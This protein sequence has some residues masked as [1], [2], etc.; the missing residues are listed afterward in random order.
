MVRGKIVVIE[1]HGEIVSSIE[2]NG[3]MYFE[4]LGAELFQ[5][6]SQIKTFDEY[7]NLVKTFNENF[8]NYEES[9]FFHCSKNYCDLK[10]NYF[11][12]WG[13]DYIYWKNLSNQNY[14]ITDRNGKLYTMLPNQTWV[15][16]FGKRIATNFQ[17]FEAYSKRE[18]EMAE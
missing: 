17:E 1:P 13:S 12:K 18:Q 14:F 6:L 11:D 4:K 16:N 9:L 7:I 2:F 10:K 15:F 3:G 8:F 5:K